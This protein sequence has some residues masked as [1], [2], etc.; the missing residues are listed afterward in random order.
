MRVDGGW[1]WKF[2]DD[3]PFALKD[4]ER[5]PEDY[6]GLTLPVALIY[7]AQSRLFT[8]M[9]REHLESLILGEIRSVA[10]ENAR[11]HLFLDQPLAF[12]DALRELC[13]TLAQDG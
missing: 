10:I 2:D 7:G 6:A 9:T 1:A 3:L 12:I 11:H 8:E 5:V 4:A 13:G